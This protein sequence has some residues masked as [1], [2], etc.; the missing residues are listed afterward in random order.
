MGVG[1]EAA[2]S[3]VQCLSERRVNIR[4]V[5]E[6][7]AVHEHELSVNVPAEFAP[8]ALLLRCD[9][10]RGDSRASHRRYHVAARHSRER[11]DC[12]R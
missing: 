2:T 6:M 5:H 1:K 11:I 4:A 12:N 3:E 10:N 7:R 9:G 8:N